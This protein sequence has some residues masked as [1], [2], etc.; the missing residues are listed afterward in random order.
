ME[1]AIVNAYTGPAII[2]LQTMGGERASNFCI[3]IIYFLDNMMTIAC[4]P[5]LDRTGVSHE[6][7]KNLYF[8]R[9]IYPM[10]FTCLIW[11]II[12][13]RMK[14]MLGGDTDDTRSRQMSGAMSISHTRIKRNRLQSKGVFT[15]MMTNDLDKILFEDFGISSAATNRS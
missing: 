3:V 13:F 6:D 7:Y 14:K 2:L 1:Y 15:Y 11:L 5:L 10:C 8:E 12:I 4:T 9:T